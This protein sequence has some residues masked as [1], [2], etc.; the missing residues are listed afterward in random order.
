M[1]A[2]LGMIAHIFS[3]KTGTLTRNIM[4]F[5][6]CACAGQIYEKGATLRGKVSQPSVERDLVEIMAVC[7]TVV[8]DEDGYQAE[9][10]DEE[11]LVKGAAELGMKFT[12][13]STEGVEVDGKRYLVLATIPFNSTRKRMSALV[14]GPDG[15]ARILCKGADNIMFGLTGKDSFKRFAGGRPA[16]DD[17]LQ[18]FSRV[19]LRTLVLGR[20]D[21]S[22]SEKDKFLKA[23]RAAE[24]ATDDRK[25]KL[26][27]AAALIERDFEIVGA[28]AIEDRLQ[29]GVPETIHEL[30]KAEI[31]LWVLTGDKVETAINIAK[32]A[33][34][35]T[36]D[37]FLVK[38]PAEG[39]TKGPEGD[40]GLGAQLT[41]L[42]AVVQRAATPDPAAVSN[43]SALQE[44]TLR[45]P[46]DDDPQRTPASLAS[47][48]LALVVEGATA[49]ETILGNDE[50]EQR[51]LKLANVCKAVVACRVSPAQKRLI[52]GLVRRKDTTRPVTL[53]IGDGAND[54][55]MIQEAHIG[56]GISGKEGRQAVNNSDFAIGQFRFLKP[57][58]LKHGRRNYRRMSKVIVYSFFKNIVLTFVL[59]YYQADC[60]WSGTSFYEA[61]VYSGFNFFLAFTPLAFG[62][63]D[64]DTSA[65]TVRKYPRLY[66]AGAFGRVRGAFSRRVSPR[67]PVSR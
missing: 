16:L 6:K 20:R 53:A 28:T 63:F 13:R 39:A 2:D 22:R 65:E 45:E 43:R 64:V 67:R 25:G 33:K 11:A 42:E 48:H 34:L 35:L 40:W 57:L 66:A 31:K 21:V 37:M 62:W 24:T 49:M 44:S 8:P 18:Q 55:G 54:V 32:S 12:A 19:G 60:G 36:D 1:N 41:A 17:C 30:A 61:W 56:V 23:W 50:L 47:D 58:L 59:F 29:D 4:E 9:S 52:V 15:K 14:Q 26:A 46:L 3:D 5:K 27:E 38:L 51:F 10:P 7:H